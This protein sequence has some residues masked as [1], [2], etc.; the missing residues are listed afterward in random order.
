MSTQKTSDQSQPMVSSRITLTGGLPS[1]T[2]NRYTWGTI[3]AISMGILNGVSGINTIV[4]RIQFNTH[5]VIS[6]FP[7]V[8]TRGNSGQA[9]FSGGGVTSVKDCVGFDV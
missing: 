1:L 4:S 8:L 5:K 6:F 2:G 9:G 7:G 3:F